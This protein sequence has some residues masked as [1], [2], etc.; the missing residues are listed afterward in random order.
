MDAKQHEKAYYAQSAN[1]VMTDQGVSSD[2]LS[3]EEVQHRQTAFGLNQL[4]ETGKKS[5][6]RI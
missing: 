6:L 5:T 1:Q 3:P 4:E 2:G